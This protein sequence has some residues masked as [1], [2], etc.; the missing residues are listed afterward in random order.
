MKNI[1]KDADRHEKKLE[2]KELKKEQ[3]KERRQ[4]E[5]REDKIKIHRD[6]KI[7]KAQIKY[8]AEKKVAKE[9]K[10]GT[11]RSSSALHEAEKFK[12]AKE[13]YSKPKKTCH[14]SQCD[15]NNAFHVHAQKT[16]PDGS[17]S[18]QSLSE[19]N[20]TQSLAAQAKKVNTESD[21]QEEEETV[22]EGDTEED[23]S[24]DLKEGQKFKTTGNN[25]VNIKNLNFGAK[26]TNILGEEDGEVVIEQ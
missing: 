5:D 7:S 12:K 15:V 22:E 4:L 21:T 2:I 11:S 1:Q 13:C 16:A 10:H 17:N 19:N 9:M 18:T 23:K 3:K 6:E 26:M 24:G 20:K 25:Q 8:E 14:G